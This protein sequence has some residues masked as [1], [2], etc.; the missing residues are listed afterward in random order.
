MLDLGLDVD[1]V[2][3]PS[4][5][6]AGTLCTCAASSRPRVSEPAPCLA[7]ATGKGGGRK[8]SWGECI[9]LALRLKGKDPVSSGRGP[10]HPKLVSSPS[11]V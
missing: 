7:S 1:N 10:P 4:S 11:P 3:W 8:A 5:E 9:C 2:P 6:A